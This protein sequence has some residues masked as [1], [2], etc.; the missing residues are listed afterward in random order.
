MQ[1]FLPAPVPSVTTY[2]VELYVGDCIL[3]FQ[4]CLTEFHHVLVVVKL[5]YVY[6]VVVLLCRCFF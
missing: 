2:Q 1:C 4:Y 3:H 6:H 5:S